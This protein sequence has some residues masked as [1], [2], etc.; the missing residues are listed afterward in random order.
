M[1]VARTSGRGQFFCQ[2]P[3]RAAYFGG[4]DWEGDA[5]NAYDAKA[6]AWSAFLVKNFP[7]EGDAS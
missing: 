4:F 3:N 2:L 5:D 6:K 7:E 1:A